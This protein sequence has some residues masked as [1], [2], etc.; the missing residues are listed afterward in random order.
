MDTHIRA[1]FK[2]QL[3]LCQQ[4]N[5]GFEMHFDYSSNHFIL[6]SK[7]LGRSWEYNDGAVAERPRGSRRKS[8]RTTTRKNKG[9]NKYIPKS[10]VRASHGQRERRCAN[11][12]SSGGPGAR[13]KSCVR[14]K[15]VFY[16]DASC[17]RH[18]WKHHRNPCVAA[19]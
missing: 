3:I 7:C 2:E 16:C 6:T 9:K 5:V 10:V 19:D 17:Q 13:P 12:S 15:K 4:L 18:H 1:L 11:C 14:C 8:Q